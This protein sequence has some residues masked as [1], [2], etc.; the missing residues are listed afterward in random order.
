MQHQRRAKKQ[1]GFCT[2]VIHTQTLTASG[3]AA[4]KLACGQ[5]LMEMPLVLGIHARLA[6]IRGAE[7]GEC[8]TWQRKTR[9][10]LS[11]GMCLA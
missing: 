3:L 8:N 9:N 6:S 10:L 5:L 1:G 2:T 4:F 11:N 7:N